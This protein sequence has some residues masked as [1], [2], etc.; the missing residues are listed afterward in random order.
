[1][2]NIELSHLPVV[3]PPGSLAL[4]GKEEITNLSTIR[5]KGK[6]DIPAYLH[7]QTAHLWSLAEDVVV[8]DILS[9]LWCK[10]LRRVQRRLIF[11][12]AQYNFFLIIYERWC[13]AE[14]GE[15]PPEVSL[16]LPSPPCFFDSEPLVGQQM[17][18]C[19]HAPREQ[20]KMAAIS[21]QEYL[22]RYLSNNDEGK[23][24][25]RKK[26]PKIGAKFAKSV[27]VDDDVSLSE[28]R[29]TTE[30]ETVTELNAD[31][32]PVVYDEDG[33]TAISTEHFKKREEDLK[34]M[35][36]PVQ[37]DEEET[38]KKRHDSDSDASP[39][40]S[41]RRHDSSDASPPRARR[42]HD[43]SDASP[44]RSRRRH[45]S[46]DASPPRK[47]RSESRDNSPPRNSKA[48]SNS[49]LR[50]GR[51]L[52]SPDMSPPR[53][54]TKANDS[55]P[56]LS[57]SRFRKQNEEGRKI[58]RT[59]DSSRSSAR[60]TH[61]AEEMNTRRGKGSDS[62]ESPARRA[63]QRHDSPDQ[64]PPRRRKRH[65]SDLSP[66]RKSDSDQSPPRRGGNYDSDLSPPRRG[67]GSDS[68]QS[69][70]RKR[71]VSPRGRNRKENEKGQAGEV[72]VNISFSKFYLGSAKGPY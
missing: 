67:R 44:P 32:A 12:R 14:R 39:P 33:V 29:Q 35:W 38:E 71:A 53:R 21:K 57:H 17:L 65:D 45:D 68:D 52:E 55:P 11:E 31:E 61:R 28:I 34:S 13:W 20:F 10:S 63:I 9:R 40:R 66:P 47:T 7:G 26:K 56:A 23:K 15:N 16:F 22:K 5:R 49:G 43:S 18:L 4:A 54:T 62:D 46:S 41:R 8:L 37:A 48:A 30:T 51:T 1:M 70:P 2:T 64:S 72:L 69:P 6:K 50:D 60:R 42:R 25:K 58:S 27:V 19:T 59:S 3:D 24:K 36:V